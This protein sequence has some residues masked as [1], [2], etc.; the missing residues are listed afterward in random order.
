MRQNSDKHV[1]STVYVSEPSVYGN[2][3]QVILSPEQLAKDYITF[4]QVLE[5]FPCF[6]KSRVFGP[7]I[8][9]VP[10]IPDGQ[11]MIQA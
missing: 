4:H 6:S 9:P 2:E 8:N 10:Y 11:K 5:A 3:G 7:D 1:L